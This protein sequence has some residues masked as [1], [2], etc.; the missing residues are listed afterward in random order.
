MEEAGLRIGTSGYSFEDWRGVFYPEKL[1]KGKMLDHYAKHFSCVEINSTYYGIPAP[2]VFYRMSEKTP[3]DFEFIVKVHQ[4]VTHRRHDPKASMDQ[5]MSAVAPL[6]VD[7]KLQGFL[8]QFPWGFKYSDHRLDYLKWLAEACAPFPV[9]VE[10][11]NVSWVRDAVYHY[12][13]DNKIGY[14][15][16]DEPGMRGLLPQQN[17]ASTNVGY[18]RFHGRNAITWW[19]SSKGDRYDYNYSSSELGEWLIKIREMRQSTEKTYLFFNNCHLG[20]AII[21]AEQMRD[22][23][24]KEGLMKN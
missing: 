15:C 5:L 20:Q 24:I 9:F 7:R 10:F 3:D 2:Q 19:D 16:V 17:I 11:R 1:P 21:N 8:A 18:V 14:C 13:Q 6:I 4:E 12:L 23:L 22:L